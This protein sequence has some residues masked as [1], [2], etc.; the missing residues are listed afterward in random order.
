MDIEQIKNQIETDFANIGSA[1]A[2]EEI[3]PE[4]PFQERPDRAA[5]RYYSYF[6]AGERASFGQQVN[7]LKQKAQ[8]LIEAKEKILCSPA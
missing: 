2:L 6:A 8:S 7:A 3:P 4:I 5:H 1:Q